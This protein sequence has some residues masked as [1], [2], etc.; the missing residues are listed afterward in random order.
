MCRGV[1]TIVAHSMDTESVHEEH[2]GRA[3]ELKG[4]FGGHSGTDIHLGRANANKRCFVSCI[5][6]RSSA[7]SH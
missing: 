7:L 6:C 1:D 2:V 3:I 4:L 5:G